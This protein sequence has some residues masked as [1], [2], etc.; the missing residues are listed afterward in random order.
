[1]KTIPVSLILTGILA[2][3]AALA[4]APEASEP[5]P[6]RGGGG[7]RGQHAPPMER[8]K[9]AD[10]N[11]D[12]SIS[13]EEFKGM[14]RIQNLPDEKRENLFK[15]LD[16]DAD[17]RLGR[18][19]IARMG[20]PHDGK[21]AP[22]RRLWE[23]DVDKSGGVSF[24]EFKQGPFFKKL[25][26]EK[27]QVVFQRLDANGDGMITPKDKPEPSFRREGEPGHQ[28]GPDGRRM[29]PR[30]MIRQLDQNGDGSLSFE[31]FR[32][33]P[34]VKHLTED[35]QEDRFEAM[36]Q[37]GDLKLAPDDFPPPAPG[38]EGQKRPDGP[39]PAGKE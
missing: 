21:G 6:Q 3:V 22:M 1:M 30:Q 34:A 16:K 19:E 27:Q 17:G 31:E 28:G 15:R 2:Q 25:T 24:E 26:P 14:P 38:A 4:Q 37:N 39:P 8:W 5:P 29:E 33:W 13:M 32:S 9:A 11:G 18:Q 36:D 12:G 10:R 35:E 7:K 20:R 23:L